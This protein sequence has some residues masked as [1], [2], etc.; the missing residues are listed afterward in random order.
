MKFVSFL[1]TIILFMAAGQVFAHD[2]MN[3]RVADEKAINSLMDDFHDA[4]AKADQGRYLGYFTRDGVFMGTDDWER[5]PLNPDFRTYV[6]ERFKDGKGWAYKAVERHIAFSPDAKVA[7]FDEITTSEKWGLFRGTGV[8]FKEDQGWTVAHYSM[9]VLG[10]NEV[11][12]AVS[13]LAKA[14]VKRRNAEKEE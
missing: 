11:W 5:W 14:A 3:S 2:H 12:V 13:D 1:T 6:A 8:L 9:S 10:P 4:A 7:W